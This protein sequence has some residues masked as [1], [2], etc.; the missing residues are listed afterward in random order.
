MKENHRTIHVRFLES[1][2]A[3]ITQFYDER[4]RSFRRRPTEVDDEERRQK[5][6]AV[7]RIDLVSREWPSEGVTVNFF[8]KGE[9]VLERSFSSKRQAM[10][11]IGNAWLV[12]A[13]MTFED[14]GK[15]HDDTGK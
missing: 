15:K 7:D 1:T 6:E 11:R 8:F 2:V 3:K 14:E 4:I 5:I 10:L 12:E 13:T 9:L